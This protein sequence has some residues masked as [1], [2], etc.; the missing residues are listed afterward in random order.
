MG[1]SL[2]KNLRLGGSGG[3]VLEHRAVLPALNVSAVV[4]DYIPGRGL[5]GRALFQI[6]QAT[7]GIAPLGALQQSRRSPVGALE[8]L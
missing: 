2:W 4:D 5:L 1:L 6:H 8:E 3:D 7:V